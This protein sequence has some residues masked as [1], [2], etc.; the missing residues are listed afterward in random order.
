ML[1]ELTG[2]LSAVLEAN[3]KFYRALREGN[4][5]WME[6]VWLPEAEG[7]P[8]RVSCAHPG[9]N[10]IVGRAPVMRS[11]SLICKSPTNMVI[12]QV[13]VCTCMRK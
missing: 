5:Q 12:D 6:E 11:W 7:Q 13:K 3:N 1:K 4:M 2:R 10:I 8:S 9:A